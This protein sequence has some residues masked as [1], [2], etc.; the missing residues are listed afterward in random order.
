MGLQIKCFHL[1]FHEDRGLPPEIL[2]SVW[3][4]QN[5]NTACLG[6]LEGFVQHDSQ[7]NGGKSVKHDC[8]DD[9]GDVSPLKTEDVS[10]TK[11]RKEER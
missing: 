6:S 3:L 1:H 2:H 5:L 7:T 11:E 9:R 8:P 10:V 4:S